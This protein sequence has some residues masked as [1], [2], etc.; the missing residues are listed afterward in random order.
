MFECQTYT[1]IYGINRTIFTLAESLRIQ[2]TIL[3]IDL[4]ESRF[5][6]KPYFIYFTIFKHYLLKYQWGILSDI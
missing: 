3:N 4:M 6:N 1:C 5:I 2:A